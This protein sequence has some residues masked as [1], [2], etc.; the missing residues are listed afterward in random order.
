MSIEPYKSHYKTALVTCRLCY[1]HHS[2]GFFVETMNRRDQFHNSLHKNK[3]PACVTVRTHRFFA[4]LFSV[5]L[6]LIR[7]LLKKMPNF[8]ALLASSYPH[9]ATLICEL[10][11]HVH[12]LHDRLL[13]PH[14]LGSTVIDDGVCFKC[15][16]SGDTRLPDRRFARLH[17]K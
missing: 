3:H 12:A 13:F 9:V 17:P 14:L 11:V 4:S 1:S 5:W 10:S 8:Q 15:S 7:T 16:F 2:A 6:P